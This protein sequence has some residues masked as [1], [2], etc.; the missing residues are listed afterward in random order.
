MEDPGGPLLMDPLPKVSGHSDAEPVDDAD[1]D[2]PRLV[3]AAAAPLLSSMPAPSKPRHRPRRDSGALVRRCARGYPGGGGLWLV[4][5]A[6]PARHSL[7]PPGPRPR[8]STSATPCTAPEA[9]RLRRAR[10]HRCVPRAHMLLLDRLVRQDEFGGCGPAHDEYFA[11]SQQTAIELG[12]GGADARWRA[13]ADRP[14][15]PA[16]TPSARSPAHTWPSA[17][18]RAAPRKGAPHYVFL[19]AAVSPPIPVPP[20]PLDLDPELRVFIISFSM[21]MKRADVPDALPPPPAPALPSPAR[22]ASQ[23]A[24]LAPASRPAP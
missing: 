19:P 4:E 10:A 7:P 6:S 20:L 12:R 13:S 17:T 22:G 5:H 11:E 18:T 9:E 1:A 15:L 2:N 16:A 21:L 3:L 14:N 8:T 24:R 23:R